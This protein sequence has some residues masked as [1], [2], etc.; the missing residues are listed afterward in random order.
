MWHE[1]TIK[2][3]NIFLNKLRLLTAFCFSPLTAVTDRD[4]LIHIKKLQAT[5]QWR[6]DDG[7]TLITW[8]TLLIGK[9]SVTLGGTLVF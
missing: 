4:R 2:L 6:R 7:L 1:I 9:D 3:K 8:A 5:R